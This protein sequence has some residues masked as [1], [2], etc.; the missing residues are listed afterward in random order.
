MGKKA[1]QPRLGQGPVRDIYTLPIP[2]QLDRVRGLVEFLDH[3]WEML[4]RSF[5]ML[6]PAATDADLIARFH[7]TEG[8]WGFGLIKLQLIERCV[9]SIYKLLA[10]GDDTNPSLLTLVR[11]FLRGNRKRYAELLE[12]LRSDYSD[13]HK[14][15]SEEERRTRPAWEI[16]MF[17]QADEEDAAKA[18]AEFDER[19]D[20]IAADW[21]RLVE[22]SNIIAPVRGKWVAH[23][24]LE[25]DPVTKKYKTVP[26]PSV[27][28]VYGTIAR[29]VPIITDSVMHLLG[30]FRNLAIDP[31]DV[32]NFAKRDAAAFWR[33]T[34]ATAPRP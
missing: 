32:R 4:V 33:L 19:A 2:E 1:S 14:T 29:V 24:E 9:L 5:E 28:E 31:E 21:P 34:G 27:N 16:A 8:S 7:M 15:I 26:L 6:V 12:I 13:W 20:A 23:R 25:Y 3:E 17:E 22:V 10:D 18:R 30:L 11:P